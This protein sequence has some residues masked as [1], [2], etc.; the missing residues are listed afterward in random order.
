LPNSYG[1]LFLPKGMH[2]A[3]DI[4]D[5][6]EDVIRFNGFRAVGLSVTALI[7]RNGMIARFS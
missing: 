3:D 1:S 2:Q 6:L 5:Q 4:P 7:R